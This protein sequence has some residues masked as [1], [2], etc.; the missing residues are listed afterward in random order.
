[1][2]YLETRLESFLPSF[3]LDSSHIDILHSPREFVVALNSLISE[4]K[5]RIFLSS[6]YIGHEEYDLK[7]ALWTSLAAHPNLNLHILIDALR[8]TRES[9]AASSASLLASLISDFGPDRVGVRLFQNPAF[10]GTVWQRLLP[11]RFREVWGLTHMKMY[12]ADDRVIISGANLSRDYFTNRQDRY[13][14][15]NCPH[16]SD[17]LFSIQKIIGSLSYCLLPSVSDR[18]GFVLH[19]PPTNPCRPA[20]V[21]PKCFQYTARKILIP[22][23]Y[24]PPPVGEEKTQ[25]RSYDTRIYPLLQFT[26]LLG[27]NGSTEWRALSILFEQFHESSLFSSA[28]WTFSTAYFSRVPILKSA[29]LNIGSGQQST[30][31]TA[32][33]EANGFF[34]SR[35]LSSFL[36]AAYKM[37]TLD[38]MGLANKYTFTGRTHFQEWRRG[39]HGQ[40]EGWTYHAKGFWISI[41]GDSTDMTIIGSSNFG[42][43][44]QNLDLELD[45]LIMTKS[46][47]LKDKMENERREILRHA[48]EMASSS[49][50]WKW[51]EDISWFWVL[52]LRLAMVFLGRLL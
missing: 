51:F 36:P 31:V 23:I 12:G 11:R 7:Q 30:I 13:Y 3:E 17:Y 43:R 8:G 37:A 2:D 33:P 16:L 22:L 4:A 47:A 1:M 45:L 52:L 15:I 50:E 48:R 26:P 21:D 42:H 29:V 46:L 18:C 40:P 20:T 41:D 39:T 25:S 24:R 32:A 35:G 9:P 49:A 38:F 27:L 19:W 34:G 5:D 6:L 10:R 14:T 28:K 44:S